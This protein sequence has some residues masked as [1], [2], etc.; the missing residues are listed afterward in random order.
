[1]QGRGY[2][3]IHFS[4]RLSIVQRRL[5]ERP[6]HPLVDCL[7]PLIEALKG[8]HG[9][10]REVNILW[11]ED[12]STQ[13]PPPRTEPLLTLCMPASL[14]D[15]QALF[16]PVYH[17]VCCPH[18]GDFHSGSCDMMI[19]AAL[20][21]AMPCRSPSSQSGALPCGMCCTAP[22]GVSLLRERASQLPS[23]RMP[24]SSPGCGCRRLWAE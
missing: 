23:R 22:T 15:P 21:Q 4:P 18:E 7:Y 24:L 10:V 6:D 9:A 13:V 2:C 12:M 16:E 19:S 8:F 17:T 3:H 11:T 20:M 14:S 5:N 1:M